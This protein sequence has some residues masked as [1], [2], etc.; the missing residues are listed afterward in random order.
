MKPDALTGLSVLII[1]D[2]YGSRAELQDRLLQKTG[3]LER[4]VAVGFCSGQIE[5]NGKR[6]NDFNVIKQA[7]AQRQW[8]LVLLDLNFADSSEVT[9]IPFGAEVCRALIQDVS[10]LPLVM[11]TS[12]RSQDLPDIIR[13]TVPY[14]SK[15]DL[16]WR[17][18]VI[19]GF[20]FGASPVANKRLT[21][22]QKRALLELQPSEIA[23]SEVMLKTFFDVFRLADPTAEL[24]ECPNVTLVGE[25]GCGKEIFARYYHRITSGATTPYI[26]L[27]VNSIQESLFESEMFGY[28]KGGFTGA[29]GEKTGLVTAAGKGTLFLDEIGALDVGS[30]KK[31]LRLLE[32]R[33]Y[34]RVGDNTLMNAACRFIFAT[35]DDINDTTSFRGDLYYRLGTTVRIPR[36]C[37]HTEDIAELV[38][39]FLRL[40]GKKLDISSGTVD[41]LQQY[42]FPGNIRELREIVGR[43][44]VM[45]GANAEITVT[46][47]ETVLHGRSSNNNNSDPEQFQS[48]ANL[49]PG[50][51][52]T[53][54]L[55][56][57]ASIL[58]SVV[59]N[60]NDETLRGGILQIEAA[61]ENLV[62]RMYKTALS[63]EGNLTNAVR[64]MLGKDD[65]TRNILPGDC[66]R[67]VEGI[68]DKK[69]LSLFRSCMK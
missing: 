46:D 4:R 47:V 14:L 26:T 37:E 18:L 8:S 10:G 28:K 40:R 50:N 13:G 1:D 58:D 5:K 19:H 55:K 34:R 27:N 45:K 41:R 51:L 42:H 35:N 24:R 31:L 39:H 53:L 60:E 64:Y 20:F 44:A 6:Y 9:P 52:S 29:V 49:P 38:R 23:I 3:L 54:Q 61:Y 25:T 15:E 62:K 68:I 48:P 56:D 22:S 32:N 7:V 17:S 43:F 33:E 66:K 12:E 59:I 63:R 65:A 36:L 67:L 30:Q 2:E 57:L 16:S 69:W 21:T 11:L